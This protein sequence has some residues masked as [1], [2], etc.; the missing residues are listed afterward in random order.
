VKSVAELQSSKIARLTTKIAVTEVEIERLKKEQFKAQ[1]AVQKSLEVQKT[2]ALAILEKRV[3]LEKA[4]KGTTDV[5]TKEEE[6]SL[7]SA[8]ADLETSFSDA[9]EAL[10]NGRPQD[11]PKIL[12][13]DTLLTK[14]VAQTGENVMEKITKLFEKME[15]EAKEGMVSEGARMVLDALAKKPIEMG[16]DAANEGILEALAKALSLEEQKAGR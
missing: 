12:D 15:K 13:H 9:K 2:A 16:Q 6:E 1:E 14:S 10:A 8:R 11:V 7:L 3:A 5:T 4:M